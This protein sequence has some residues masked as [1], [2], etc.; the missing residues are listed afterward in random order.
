MGTILFFG[1]IA[2]ITA[3]LIV[4]SFLPIWHIKF[5]YLFLNKT[6]SQWEKPDSTSGMSYWEL[7]RGVN[8]NT[9]W[10]QKWV[11]VYANC[12]NIQWKVTVF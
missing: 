2:L 11:D 9:K 6:W 5:R 4:A 3:L 10:K 12:G 8:D 1:S 7:T